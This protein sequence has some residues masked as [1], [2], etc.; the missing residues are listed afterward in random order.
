MG[1]NPANDGASA[2]L[3][4]FS[5]LRLIFASAVIFSHSPNILTGKVSL[6]PHFGQVTI[7]SLAVDG[8]FLVSGYLITKSFDRDNSVTDYFSKR[9]L[10]IYPAFLFNMAIGLFLLGRLSPV[11]TTFLLNG[12]FV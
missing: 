8:F 2:K 12:L 5:S 4:N 11:T 10:R 9:I 3:N 6:E 7:G 1:Y